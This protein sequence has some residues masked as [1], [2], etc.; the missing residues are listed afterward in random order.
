MGRGEVILD[1]SSFSHL[2]LSCAALLAI[3]QQPI[4]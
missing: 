4:F 1:Y 3:T 2:P